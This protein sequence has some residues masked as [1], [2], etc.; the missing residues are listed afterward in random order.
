MKIMDWF[1]ERLNQTSPTLDYY[2]LRNHATDFAKLIDLKIIKHSD[3]IESIP[4]DLCDTDHLIAPFLNAKGELVISCD[5][6]RRIVNPDELKIWTIN[7]WV[8]AKNV[9]SKNR[10]ITKR[11]F[12]Q[13]H[14]A[15]TVSSTKPYSDAN[16]PVWLPVLGITIRG[17]QA[18]K[19]RQLSKDCKKFKLNPTDQALVYFLYY[20]FLKNNNACFQPDRLALEAS[21]GD[22]QKSKDYIENRI[23]KINKGIKGLVAEG[24]T[25]LPVLV[26]FEPKRGY[27]LNP[28]Q[29]PDKK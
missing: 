14:F 6:S 19:G 24:V 21:S 9:N 12:E 13:T 11:L 29:F 2:D 28:K 4:C 18:F 20:E 7:G 17:S 3:N 1:I 8:L 16:E 27:R 23:T 10:V 15:S 26:K 22:K 5:G 25:K